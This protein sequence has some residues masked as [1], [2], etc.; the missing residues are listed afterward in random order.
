MFI[1]IKCYATL[2]KY[3]SDN[4][5]EFPITPNEYLFDVVNRLGIEAKEIKIAFV[6]GKH[7]TLDTKLQDGDK[8]ALFPAVGGG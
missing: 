3:Q 1:S 7:A 5:N 4:S 8:V 2:A 6:N